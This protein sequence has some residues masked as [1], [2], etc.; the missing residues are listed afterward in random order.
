[1]KIS[2]LDFHAVSSGPRDVLTSLGCKVLERNGFGTPMGLEISQ[3]LPSLLVVPLPEL[4]LGRGKIIC[5][6]SF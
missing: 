2:R 6:K 5:G 1:M 4:F 3:P